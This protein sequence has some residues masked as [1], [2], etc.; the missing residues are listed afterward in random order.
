MHGHKNRFSS[1][2]AVIAFLLLLVVAVFCVF[3]YTGIND[4]IDSLLNPSFSVQYNGVTYSGDDNVIVLPQDGKAKFKVR[5]VDS[6]QVTVTPNVTAETDFSYNVG[7]TVYVFGNTNLTNFFVT[8]GC[9][10]N[11]YFVID[12]TKDLSVE[13]VL[14]KLHDNA[15]ITLNGTAVEVPYAG[16]ESEA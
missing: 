4:K 6:Y 16:R 5:G 1:I 8:D 11:G 15:E 9:V 7:D 10:E 2:I 14:S 3:R 12:C 13:S